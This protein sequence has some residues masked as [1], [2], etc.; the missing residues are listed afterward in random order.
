MRFYKEMFGIIWEFNGIGEYLSF[1]VGRI[2]GAII[3]IAVM[4]FLIF[5]TNV[6]DD[7]SLPEWPYEPLPAG[8]YQYPEHP[9]EDTVYNNQ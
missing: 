1:I 5:H 8:F 9:E 2:I 6:F 4:W 7:D 3:F